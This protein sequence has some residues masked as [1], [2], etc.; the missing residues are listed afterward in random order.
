MNKFKRVCM[1]D[2]FP[3]VTLIFP[4]ESLR[5]LYIRA[6]RKQ[7]WS[8]FIRFKDVSGFGLQAAEGALL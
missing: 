2:G 6:K 4:T 3:L 7:G 8:Y 1:G 5:D